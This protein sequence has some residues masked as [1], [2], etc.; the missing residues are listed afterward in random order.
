[1]NGVV[2]ASG[3]ESGGE[4][5]ARESLESFW[6]EVSQQAQYSP[7]RRS[8]LDK[9]LGEWSLDHSPSYLFFDVMTRFASPY[10]FNPLNANRC[11]TWS[12]KS[13]ISTR[14]IAVRT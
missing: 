1:M 3:M 11:A 13:S 14:C 10:E 7:I 5:G 6:R 12:R 8:P 2:L 9:F 4:D